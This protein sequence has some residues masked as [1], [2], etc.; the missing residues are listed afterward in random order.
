MKSVLTI[1]LTMLLASTAH[2]HRFAPSSL[3][4]YEGENAHYEVLWK[5]PL[6]TT[7]NIPLRPALPEGCSIKQES[8]PQLEGTGV[9]KRWLLNC[10][11]LA[12]GLVGALVGVDG[13]AQ[14]QAS[15]LLIYSYLDGRSWQQVLNTEV[16]T[17][18]IPSAPTAGGV[19]S[20]YI[21]LGA[22]HIWAG[23]D[24][25]LFVL[26]LVLLVVG[27]RSLLITV[28]SF[29]VGHSITL[30]MVTLGVFDY[31]VA[32]VEFLIALSIFMLALEVH[33]EKPGWFARFP[34][35]V[36][37]GFG[38]LHGMG[39]AGA[40]GEVGLPQGQVPLALLSFNIG[41]ELGQIAFI[42]L[43]LATGFVVRR[44]FTLWQSRLEPIAIYTM[45]GV[46]AMWCYERGFSVLGF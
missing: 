15:A 32:L 9:V 18:T 11:S 6:Q 19:L 44:Y 24:H 8:E 25:L 4:I 42:L 7:S 45:G 36:A 39:F 26:G 35:A 16:S 14:N 22:E 13:L 34:W 28:T 30:A 40:L 23:P 3:Q 31:P 41:I 43:V 27:F 1:C 37:V 29:T 20:S 5:T 12:D 38:L 10:A 33:A 2:A 46:A 21:V 17:V